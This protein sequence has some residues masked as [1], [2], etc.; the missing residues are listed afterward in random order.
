MLH[1]YALANSLVK[2][3]Q[4]KEKLMSQLLDQVR[5]VMRVRHYQ[6]TTEK[7]YIHWM[8][9]FIFFHDLRHPKDMGAAGK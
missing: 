3:F 9:Q 1:L 6:Y 5:E 4:V 2:T 7:T 8:K